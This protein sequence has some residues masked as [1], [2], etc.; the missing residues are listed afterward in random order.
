MTVQ[1]DLVE[2]DIKK[3]EKDLENQKR[4]HQKEKKLTLKFKCSKNQELEPKL[5]THYIIIPTTILETKKK[6]RQE[7]KKKKIDVYIIFTLCTKLIVVS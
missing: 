7:G 2:A 6:R 5:I 1:Y 4:K 3:N